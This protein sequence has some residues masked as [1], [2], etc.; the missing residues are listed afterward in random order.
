MSN[1]S[2]VIPTAATPCH[3]NMERIEDEL[4]ES[5]R[6][7]AARQIGIIRYVLVLKMVCLFR[8]LSYLLDSIS[9]VCFYEAFKRT[10]TVCAK[11]A[12]PKMHTHLLRAWW[13]RSFIG[14]A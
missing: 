3:A 5:Q 8:K 9:S 4:A 11:L 12:S 13:S 10:I 1:V 7:P 6:A 14:W 2:S